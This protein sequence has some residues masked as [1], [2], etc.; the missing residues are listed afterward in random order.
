MIRP[1]RSV[2]HDVCLSPYSATGEAM[3]RLTG[4]AFG[5]GEE[6]GPG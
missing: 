1:S 5:S 6:E 4:L 2:H 3:A